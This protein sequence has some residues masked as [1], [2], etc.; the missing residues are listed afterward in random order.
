MNALTPLH[1]L[2]VSTLAASLA[3]CG[4]LPD[5]HASLDRA[6]ARHDAVR[7]DPQVTRLAPNELMRADAALTQADAAAKAGADKAD[8]DHLAYIAQQRVVIAQE[9]ATSRAAQAQVDRIAAERD[10]KRLMLR[11]QEA[12]TAQRQLAQSRRDNVRQDVALTA[13]NT[14][15]SRDQSEL[16]NKEVR[17]RE[18]ETQLTDLQAVRTDRGMVLTLGDTLF[19][20]GR[21]TLSAEGGRSMGKLVDYLKRDPTR[22]AVVEGHTDNVGS[23]ASNLALSERR[24]EAVL[25][26]LVRQGVRNDQLSTRSYGSAQPVAS[27]ETAAGRQMNRRVEVLLSPVKVQ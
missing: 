14:R 23:Q 11:T 12:E 18:L 22:G 4:A 5:R 1:L 19:E 15:M 16:A 20:T 7:A 24:A 6:H 27:N 21:A 9:A 17:V 2:L 13:A 25:N 3:A 26:A 8:I 10:Q